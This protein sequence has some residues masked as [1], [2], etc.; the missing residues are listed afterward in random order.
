MSGTAA[1]DHYDRLL[2][3]HYTWMLGG[4]IPA[5]A[6]AQARLLRDLGVRP[7]AAGTLAVDL[8][9]GPGPQSLALV[10]L[11]FSPVLAVDSSRAL[12]DELV[13]YAPDDAAVRPLHADI[14]G[15]LPE[16][17]RPGSVAA[18][19][20]MGD[21]LTHLPSHK[22][23]TQLIGDIAGALADGG[24]LVFSY[25]DLTVPLTGDDRFLPVR[26]TEDRIMTCFLEYAD[27]ATVTVHDLIHTRTGD[28]D[29][30]GGG[31]TLHTSSYPKLRI[32][33]AW[34]ADTCRAAGLRIAHDTTGP[35]GLRVLTAVR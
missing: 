25:R 11:G 15:V 13:R 16:H 26:S 12:L 35:R 3:A 34:L 4:D 32:G 21:T 9:C 27:E 28:G 8:G 33:A 6:T 18:V 7:G 30:G 19:V 31:W 14:R 20:C 5:L 24:Q 23:V 17:T 29:E 1:A 2:A 10:E 22:D